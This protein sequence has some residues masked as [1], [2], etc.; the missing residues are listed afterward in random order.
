MNGA[1][2]VKINGDL[3]IEGNLSVDVTYDLKA[4]NGAVKGDEY[5]ILGTNGT[6]TATSAAI[7]SK[8]SGFSADIID[9]FSASSVSPGVVLRIASDFVVPVLGQAS[10]EGSSGWNKI[11]K[12]KGQQF[13]FSVPVEGI[14]SGYF[15][16]KDGNPSHYLK[17]NP[18]ALD[19]NVTGIS[20]VTFIDGELS[21]KGTPE[22]AA[23]GES[24]TI[25]IGLYWDNNPETSS[26]AAA[27]SLTAISFVNVSYDVVF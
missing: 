20:D 12:W 9:S 2:A 26:P 14:D 17:A 11:E 16:S 23:Q 22:D 10:I 8:T 24:F 25:Q 7:V 1:Y 19:I 21:F 18:V 13:W 15:V 5:R 3:T 6:F 4:F 27:D